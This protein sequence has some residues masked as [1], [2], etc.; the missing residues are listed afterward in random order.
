[1]GQ[2]IE[3]GRRHF[4]IAED[5]RPFAEAQV[6]GDYHAGAFIKL[7]KQVEEQGAAG[8]AE[9]QVAKL[10]QDHQIATN[11]PLGNLSGFSLRLFLLERV[12]ELDGGVKA[13]LL[14]MMLNSLNGK[15]RCNVSLAG[16]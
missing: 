13:S 14:P 12:D 5:P 8:C 11:Q 15:S 16:S 3:Q 2:A 9:R 7:A 1:M 10:V 6:C 4:G